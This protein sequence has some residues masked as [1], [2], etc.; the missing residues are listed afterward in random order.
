MRSLR[1]FSPV[2][3]TSSTTKRSLSG[4]CAQARG[5][6][7]AAKRCC[8]AALSNA[9]PL[10]LNGHLI[11]C[12]ET[13]NYF[14]NAVPAVKIH[15]IYVYLNYLAWVANSGWNNVHRS[16]LGCDGLACAAIG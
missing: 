3:S 14:A 11:A 6:G 7:N 13:L 5:V 4:S 15:A 8:K 10:R 2:A 9:L 12:T 16:G 1:V